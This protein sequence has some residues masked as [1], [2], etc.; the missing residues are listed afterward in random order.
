MVTKSYILTTDDDDSCE[1]RSFE[2]SCDFHERL[3]E[4]TRKRQDKRANR[5][6]KK[7]V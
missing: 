5:K 6:K 4:K 2:Y 3:I 7:S 1:N